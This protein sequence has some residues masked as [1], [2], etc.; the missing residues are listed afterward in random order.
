MSTFASANN[1]F[2]DNLKW[3]TCLFCLKE[4]SQAQQFFYLACNAIAC[5]DCGKRSK[6]I[7][8]TF[9]I[10]LF[11]HQAFLR[12]DK[13]LNVHNGVVSCVFL[14]YSANNPNKLNCAHCKR[15]VSYCPIR[16]EV[17]QRTEQ[18]LSSSY[19]LFHT[20]I[21]DAFFL[22]MPQ[23]LRRLFESPLN[24]GHEMVHIQNFQEKIKS[25]IQARIVK[26]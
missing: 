1:S 4:F 12:C 3:V 23:N 26:C 17:I 20:L 25:M 7:A 2:M 19:F 5:Y 9:Y 10:H 21:F 24:L 8:Q 14:V 11:M 15:S 16:E 13:I 18:V 22:Q 6:W